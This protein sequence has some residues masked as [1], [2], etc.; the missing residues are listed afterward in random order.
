MLY[1]YLAT[2]VTIKFSWKSNCKTS[3][4]F[5][6]NKI[7]IWKILLISKLKYFEVIGKMFLVL[8]S[9]HPINLWFL[10][11]FNNKTSNQKNTRKLLKECCV[12]CFRSYYTSSYFDIICILTVLW[13]MGELIFLTSFILLFFS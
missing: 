3:P 4:G 7:H 8:H 2:W 12:S 13:A 1:K 11:Y 9:D 6:S 5:L 10:C